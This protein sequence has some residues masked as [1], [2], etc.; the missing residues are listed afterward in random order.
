MLVYEHH[1]V[2]QNREKSIPPFSRLMAI[3]VLFFFYLSY[4]I[5]FLIH[6]NKLLTIIVY[7]FNNLFQASVAQLD[8]ALGFGPGGCGFDP[9]RRAIKKARYKDSFEFL[10]RA[11]SYILNAI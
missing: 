10:Y 6:L 5:L 4:W 7:N 11:L 2:H 9:T 3:W 8:R 1:L